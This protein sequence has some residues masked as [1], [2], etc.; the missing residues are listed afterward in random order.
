MKIPLFLL[1]L[2]DGTLGYSRL[3]SIQFSLSVKICDEYYI[4]QN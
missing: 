2:L 4:G 1:L 3:L